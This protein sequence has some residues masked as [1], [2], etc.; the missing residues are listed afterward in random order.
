MIRAKYKRHR[1]FQIRDTV[2]KLVPELLVE[3][4]FFRKRF[5]INLQI[6][7]NAQI[8]DQ[9]IVV[10][11]LRA[12]ILLDLMSASVLMVMRGMAK[13]AQ[14]ILRYNGLLLF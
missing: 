4:F 8:L 9:T 1:L 11:W 10:P 12:T 7:M 3:A 2:L 5:F 13:T 6:S 14:V